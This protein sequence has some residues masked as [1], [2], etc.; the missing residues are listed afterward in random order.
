MPEIKQQL[1]NLKGND[2]KDLQHG[3][4]TLENDILIIRKELSAMKFIQEDILS[5]RKELNIVK[6]CQDDILNL[7]K[8]IKGID[9]VLTKTGE[10]LEKT[11]RRRYYWGL[12]GC[13][14]R[15]AS[16]AAHGNGSYINWNNNNSS[17][18]NMHS[19]LFYSVS[20]TNI[21]IVNPGVYYVSSHIAS[22]ESAN[23]YYL[24]LYQAGSQ[25]NAAYTGCNSGHYGTKRFARL[26]QTTTP[27]E[28]VQVYYGSNTNNYTATEENQISISYLS[29]SLWEHN[30]ALCVTSSSAAQNS[31]INWNNVDFTTNPSL[32]T[33]NGTS[34]V[35]NRNTVC[36]V[37]LLLST[38]SSNNACT[39]EI[40]VNNTIRSRCIQS[41]GNG[42]YNIMTMVDLVEFKAGERLN[43]YYTGNA[44]SYVHG[45]NTQQLSILA[46]TG[47]ESDVLSLASS[48]STTNGSFVNW[49]RHLI[50]NRTW[51]NLPNNQQITICKTGTYL[52][53]VNIS[54]TSTGNNGYLEIRLNGGTV[55]RGR[56]KYCGG[57]FQ[58]LTLS[59]NIFI[60][61]NQ[62]IQIYFTSNNASRADEFN[63]KLSIIPMQVFQY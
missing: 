55:S 15:V 12:H 19:P 50:T 2:I 46:L 30:G 24:S 48:G 4:K 37:S 57:H 54:T 39:A 44:N 16:S 7:K 23:G 18:Y 38:T 34:I 25:K 62:Y 28:V 5:I 21:T 22:Q 51:Y 35:V 20:G 32:F 59:E 29:P 42:H 13:F 33:V 36:L 56:F 45:H 58:N 63:T 47:Q 10:E 49:D 8:E 14:L 11:N 26:I 3:M 40:R 6:A 61:A 52:V 31:E 9:G 60:T 27:N 43:V 17:P 41:D 1:E 53:S